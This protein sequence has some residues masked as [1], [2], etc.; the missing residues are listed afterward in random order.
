VFPA[1]TYPT[2]LTRCDEL[3]NSR[4]ELWVKNDGLTHPLYGGN[5]VRRA[6]A[7][8]REA[9]RR[10]ARRILT[11]G[12][13]GSHHVLTMTLFAK[14]AGLDCA[15]VLIPQP[16]TEHVVETIRAALGQGL[17]PH[18]TRSTVGIPFALVSAYRPG[19]YFVPPGGSNLIGA[20]TYADAVEELKDQL[21]EGKLEAPDW[22]V[23]PF[24]SG[25]MVAGVAAGVVQ[26]GLRS[27]VVGVQVVPGIATRALCRRLF[28]QMVRDPSVA[29]P[30]PGDVL[31]L[32][33]S[34]LGEGYGF[35]TSAGEQAMRVAAKVGLQLDQ[36]YTAKAFA[37]VLR[38]LESAKASHSSATAIRVLY[39]HTL[40]ATPIEPL[41]TSAPL[42]RDLPSSVR[43]LL[44]A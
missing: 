26:H 30:P 33:D 35:A 13:V 15:A 24:G 4:V 20:R 19:D 12:P 39:W 5:K 31:V 29:R 7:L 8:I 18:A 10:G 11:V 16:R 27:K 42:E 28:R 9:Q 44:S 23:M 34:E 43:R 6:E 32:D 36:A 22:I 3:S 2:P 40:A 1:A 41:L 17:K 14:A 21:L 38:L 37:Y 25:G